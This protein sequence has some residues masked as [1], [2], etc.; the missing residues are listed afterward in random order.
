MNASGII[1][2]AAAVAL[3]IGAVAMHKAN[4]QPWPPPNAPTSTHTAPG[5]TYIPL[6]RAT[7][8]TITPY[9]PYPYN[10]AHLETDYAGNPVIVYRSQ[11]YPCH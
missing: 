10:C 2:T 8:P 1:V 3:T 9:D 7:P 6:P 4:S 11:R 5:G